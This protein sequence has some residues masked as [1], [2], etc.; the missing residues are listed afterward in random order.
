MNSQGILKSDV[1][2]MVCVFQVLCIDEA[3]ASVDLETDQLIQKTIKSEFRDSTVLTIAHRLTFTR[4]LFSIEESVCFIFCL[5]GFVFNPFVYTGVK[6]QHITLNPCSLTHP[7]LWCYK[8]DDDDDDDIT[9][10]PRCPPPPCFHVTLIEVYVSSVIHYHK[11]NV[12]S[13]RLD[14]I[15]DSD[16]VLVMDRGT[17]LELD[18]PQVLL[19]NRRSFFYRLVHSTRTEDQ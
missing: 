16:R 7:P 17:V 8:K 13:P 2:T 3:T 15:M 6:P 1:A 4:T 14:T 5:L 10:N 9:L 19:G 11:Y 18:T 12:L